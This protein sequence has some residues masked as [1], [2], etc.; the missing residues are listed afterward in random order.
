MVFHKF[1]KFHKFP[2]LSLAARLSFTG[3]PVPGESRA[4]ANDKTTEAPTPA[5]GRRVG[6]LRCREM[7]NT[8]SKPEMCAKRC[9]IYIHCLYPLNKVFQVVCLLD[10]LLGI[11]AGMGTPLYQDME[12]WGLWAATA[13]QI[14]GRRASRSG[15]WIWEAGFGSTMRLR[16]DAELQ[17]LYRIQD[18]SLYQ[19]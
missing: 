13:L 6:S 5:K 3:T 14:A 10:K 2:K 15:G 16:F 9:R 19:W 18:H 1:H 8:A 4:L 7:V 12:A 11:K 17:M